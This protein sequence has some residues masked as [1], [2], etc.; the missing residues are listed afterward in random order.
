MLT[1]RPEAPLGA[2]GKPLLGFE[3]GS[4]EKPLNPFISPSLGCKQAPFLNIKVHSV[5]DMIGYFVCDI[6]FSKK[7]WLQSPNHQ[8]ID[9][10]FLQD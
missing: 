3:V 7:V 6:A 9:R 4:S 5:L 2:S 10:S 8:P 1:G